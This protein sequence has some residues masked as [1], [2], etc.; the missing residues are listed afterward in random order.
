MEPAAPPVPVPAPTDALGRDG[1][2]RSAE[3]HDY[4]R[5]LADASPRVYAEVLGATEEGRELL[6][7]VVS[8][9]AN[10]GDL[11]RLANIARALADPRVTPSEEAELLAQ[12]GKAMVYLLGAVPPENVESPRAL[13]ELAHR[14]ATSEAPDLAEI[15]EQ[16][17]LL[18]TPV[19][20]PDGYDRTVDWRRLYPGTDVP[21]PWRGYY[22]S[23]EGLT[24]DPALVLPGLAAAVRVVERFQ[25]QEVRVASR[26][27]PELL[28][29][30]EGVVRAGSE[31]LRGVYARAQASLERGR[32]QPPYAWIFPP[33]P[34][35]PMP[36]AELAD[37]VIRHGVE[38]HRMTGDLALGDRLYPHGSL[39]VR[40]DQ[41]ARDLAV[42]LLEGRQPPAGGLGSPF[43]GR[44]EALPLFLG[45]RGVAVDEAG[46]LDVP[47]RGRDWP[48]A[49][50]ES[51]RRRRREPPP[52]PPVLLEPV[53]GIE[54]PEGR[55]EGLGEDVFLLRD[56]GQRGLLTARALLADHQ[57]DAA[58]EPF[59]AGGEDFP[60]GTLLIYG[61]RQ[62]VETAAR[63]TGLLFEAPLST[64]DVRRHI[65]DLPRIGLLHT[66]TDTESAG[67]LRLA[68][69][70]VRV[71]YQVV[72]PEDLRRG[73][74]LRRVD[75]V[76]WPATA[77]GFRELVHGHDPDLGP[78]PY[79]RTGETPS[80]GVPSTSDDVTGGMGFEGLG[81]LERFVRDGGILAVFGNSARPFVDGGL[82]PD[83]G[84]LREDLATQGAE[85]RAGATRPDHPLSYGLAPRDAFYVTSGPVW[86]TR[87]DARPQAV[88]RFG[89]EGSSAVGRAEARPPE[90]PVQ[91][92]PGVVEEDLPLEVPEEE[93]PE[94]DHLTEEGMGVEVVEEE[95]EPVTAEVL[96]APWKEPG[97]VVL[98]GDRAAGA[99]VD[100]RPAVLDLPLGEGH[101]VLF[102]FDPFPHYLRRSDFRP[103]WSLLLHW[104]DLP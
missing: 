7:V 53:A 13:A 6:L 63:E 32:T 59:R 25:P 41:P 90:T 99:L 19:A 92:V 61:P 71:S 88:W 14:L 37:L 24:D 22:A 76:L 18:L 83:V 11:D 60:P 8:S 75:V 97:P 48:P 2:P 77:G 95:P 96:P 100:S 55:V 17:V 5:S 20:D 87:E 35:D 16:A 56:A 102:A 62:A 39:V 43:V 54:R 27:V 40:S 46:V 70:R 28:R 29:W 66:W 98:A 67:W 57:V 42:A 74:L 84:R 86:G 79:R 3:I 50:E 69:D 4:L 51:R 9:E 45:A 68:L 1:A 52:E 26:D 73:D 104:N 23:A 91:E 15:R 103:V 47:V 34:A 31:L 78:L 44:L 58:E 101:V 38:A 36:R 65:V 64:P 85:L 30:L 81:E 94:E 80:F 12:G 72:S 10:L 33:D 93:A 89:H 21:P 82:L 49:E